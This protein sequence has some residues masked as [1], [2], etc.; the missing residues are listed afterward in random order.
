MVGVDMGPDDVGLHT[1]IVVDSNGAPHIAYY[2]VTNNS[3][4]HAWGDFQS[5][6][7]IWHIET[8]DSGGVGQYAN[9]AIDNS[10][11]LHIAYYSTQGLSLIHI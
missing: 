2:D 10:D 6:N 3:L 1:G 7:Y 4:K 9:L 8:V 5:S 11:N